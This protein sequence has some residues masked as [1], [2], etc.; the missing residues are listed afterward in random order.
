MEDMF[1]LRHEGRA[2]AW[3]GER[4]VSLADWVLELDDSDPVRRWMMSRAFFV[5][6]LQGGH[7]PGA[8][9]EARADHFAR[10]ALMPDDEF[11]PLGERED[12]AIAAHFGVPVA[13]VPAKR[14]DMQIH[15]AL[16][17]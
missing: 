13:Q 10:C 8:F 4:R 3:I 15:A 9:S 14:L 5:L 17:D 6:E 7:I 2:G 1:I 11:A 16:H 12:V